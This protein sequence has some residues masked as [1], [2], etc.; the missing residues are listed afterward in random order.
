MIDLIAVLPRTLAKALT[1]SNVQS[2]FIKNGG[3]DKEV[4][5]YPSF[6]G[7]WKTMQT[8]PTT[9]QYDCMKQVIGGTVKEMKKC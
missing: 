1:V 2:G 9:A 4:K 6:N 8:N 5:Q 7:M 3:I